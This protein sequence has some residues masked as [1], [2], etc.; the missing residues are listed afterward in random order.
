M[1]DLDLVRTPQN[2]EWVPVSIWLIHR[3]TRQVARLTLGERHQ[4]SAAD[5]LAKLGLYRLANVKG[6]VNCARS[7]N[8]N[9]LCADVSNAIH[10]NE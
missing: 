8:T 2:G 7:R 10:E 9:V 4:E 1:K 5:E 3:T 6:G